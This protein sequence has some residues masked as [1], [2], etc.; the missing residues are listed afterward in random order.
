MEN[1]N[2][3]PNSLRISVIDL[4]AYFLYFRSN[5]YIWVNISLLEQ[6]NLNS[7]NYKYRM[8]ILLVCVI[9]CMLSCSRKSS[10]STPEIKKRIPVSVNL[11]RNSIRCLGDYKAGENWTTNCLWNQMKISFELAN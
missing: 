11:I 5:K 3:V 2:S 6:L 10:S 9:V 7:S 8:R 1:S 4:S